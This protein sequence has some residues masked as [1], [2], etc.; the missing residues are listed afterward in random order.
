MLCILY[1]IAIGW[2]LGLAG[3]I[4]ERA[5][6][7][8]VARRWVWC[9]VIALSVGIPPVY[10]AKHTISVGDHL[11]QA[12]VGT[13]SITAMSPG[14]VARIQSFD[15][16]INGF[17]LFA[18]AALIAWGLIG[19][20]RVF[21]IVRQ[22]RARQKQLGVPTVVDGVPVVVTEIVGPATVGMWRSRVLVPRWVLALPGV[23]RKYVI[24]H[25]EE[26]RRAHDGRLLFVASLFLILLPWNIALWWQLRRLRLAVELDCDNR[27]VSALGDASAYGRLLLTVAQATSR[28]P[29]LQP[30]FLGGVGMLERRLTML[31]APTPLRHVQRYLLPVLAIAIL[32]LV[33]SLPH[34]VLRSASAVHEGAEATEIAA[35][36]HEATHR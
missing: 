16:G 8:T 13:A 28:G 32:I 26:H 34:P 31:L 17:W 35:S 4:V 5:L 6:P 18:S 19:A 21:Q 2:C 9:V 25:E 3:L 33:L 15:A 20:W 29:R 7:A 12:S 14:W 30:A 36:Q 27:V 11:A 23:Q 24:R 10:Q 1:V 22:A